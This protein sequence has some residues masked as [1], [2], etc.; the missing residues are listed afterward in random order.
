MTTFATAITLLPT[1]PSRQREATGILAPIIRAGG[2]ILY[3]LAASIDE[4]KYTI[5]PEEVLDEIRHAEAHLFAAVDA[6]TDAPISAVA[7]AY[8]TAIRLA[9]VAYITEYESWN[10]GEGIANLRSL[11]NATAAVGA[12][13]DRE[14]AGLTSY[15]GSSL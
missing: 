8:I 4:D 3:A 1:D 13:L 12:Y 5:S 11:A 7:K 9:A 10:N 14:L 2:H 6:T 15:P